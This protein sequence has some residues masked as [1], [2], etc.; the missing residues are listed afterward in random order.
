MQCVLTS[1]AA[2]S[3]PPDL[4]MCGCMVHGMH[5]YVKFGRRIY[6]PCHDASIQGR[7][8]PVC[9]C[10]VYNCRA[11]VR[12]DPVVAATGRQGVESWVRRT[13]ADG[14]GQRQGRVLSHT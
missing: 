12:N 4:G 3:A 1:G 5:L 6:A 7:T 8:D 11:S 2:V 13:S 9:S 14:M 10:I